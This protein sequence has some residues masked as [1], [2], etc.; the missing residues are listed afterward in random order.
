M[1]IA[2]VLTKVDHEKQWLLNDR[3]EATQE[4][5]ARYSLE[6]APHFKNDKDISLV[7]KDNDN[8]PANL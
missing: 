1:G 6:N 7:Q 5:Q 4:L 8:H 2:A 3:Q